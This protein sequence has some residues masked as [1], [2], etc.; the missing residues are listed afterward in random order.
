MERLAKVLSGAIPEPPDVRPVPPRFGKCWCDPHPVCLDFDVLF[1]PQSHCSLSLRDRLPASQTP[2]P[3]TV[4]P[5]NRD[6]FQRGPFAHQHRWIAAR[7]NSFHMAHQHVVRFDRETNPHTAEYKVT[8][9]IL[10]P[11]RNRAPILMPQ[12]DR[13]GHRWRRGR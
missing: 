9:G 3:D 5:W 8:A 13:E 11:L 7:Q 1:I 12:C 10:A 2:E 6:D 4:A